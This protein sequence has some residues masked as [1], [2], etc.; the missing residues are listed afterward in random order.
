M[1]KFNPPDGGSNVKGRPNAIRSNGKDD[2]VV[3]L[4]KSF[5]YKIKKCAINFVIE[6]FKNKTR[7]LFLQ[8]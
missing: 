5:T 1:P 7:V 8:L 3:T 4:K 2:E 6:I